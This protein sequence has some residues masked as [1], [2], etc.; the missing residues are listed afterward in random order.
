MSSARTGTKEQDAWQTPEE[1]LALV[2]E[3]APIDL[4]PCTSEDNPTGAKHFITEAQNGLQGFWPG[5]GLVYVNAPYSRM[6]DWAE[7]VG[8]ASGP[9]REIIAL[10]PARTDTRWWHR[11]VTYRPHAICF[12]QGRIKFNRPGGGPSQS[13]PFPSAL[14]YW[15]CDDATFARVFSKRGWVVRS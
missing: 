5:A 9:R 13:A 10:V 1:V 4:D 8:Q 3:V 7:R 2:R 11:L 15:G 14:L 12:W 6:R